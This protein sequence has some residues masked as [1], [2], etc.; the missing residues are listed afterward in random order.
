MNSEDCDPYVMDSSG[1][2]RFSKAA[3]GSRK[4]FIDSSLQVFEPI[5][6]YCYSGRL[7]VPLDLVP[8]VYLLAKRLEICVLQVALANHLSQNVTVG[9]IGELCRMTPLSQL[10]DSGCL[11]TTENKDVIQAERTLA[12]SI[13]QFLVNKADSVACS[14]TGQLSARLIVNLTTDFLNGSATSE[15]NRDLNMLSP[16]SDLIAFAVLKWAHRRLLA[17]E[18]LARLLSSD[19]EDEVQMD[20][21]SRDSPLHIP[22]QDVR[23]SDFLYFIDPDYY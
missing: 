5:F 19:E 4:V 13:C 21:D 7:S 23:V 9:T 1:L 6:N 14:L 20:S 10:I 15:R 3:K 16:Q 11:E 2:L 22:T 18:R 12:L 8:S 17:G